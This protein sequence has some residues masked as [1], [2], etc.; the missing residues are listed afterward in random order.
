M[1]GWRGLPAMGDMLL[2][3]GRLVTVEAPGPARHPFSTQL[4]AVVKVYST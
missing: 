2:S 1:A 3:R 4:D